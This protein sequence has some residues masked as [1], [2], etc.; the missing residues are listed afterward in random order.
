MNLPQQNI[1]PTLNPPQDVSSELNHVMAEMYKKNLELNERNETLAILRKID[2]IVLS[3]VTDPKLISQMVSDLLTEEEFKLLGL[4][5]IKDTLLLPLA[6]SSKNKSETIN[7]FGKDRFLTPPIPLLDKTNILIKAIDSKQ[8]ISLQNLSEVFK[9]NFSSEE[10]VNIQNEI[11]IQTLIVYPIIVRQESIGALIIGIIEKENELSVYRRSLIDR[12]VGVSGIALDNAIL[13][14]SIQEAN[15][16]LKQLDRL[17]DE[18]VSLASHELRTPMTIIKS[19]L[20]ML[21]NRK[22]KIPPEKEKAYLYRAYESTQRLINLVNDMLNVSRIESGR[23]KL[24]M[25]EL[26]LVSLIEKVVAELVPRAIQLNLTLS[27]FKPQ[28][29]ANPIYAD[30]DRVEQVLIN[31]I[32]NSFKF[33]PSGG[34]INIS[35]TPRDKDILVQV[36]DNGKGMDKI[37]MSAL[38]QKFATMGGNYLTKENIQGTGLGLYLSKSLVEL[39]GGKIWAESPGQGKGSTFSFNL[40]YVPPAKSG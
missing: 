2:E 31:L 13:Y 11:G 23:L 29:K 30:S 10:L 22:A 39:H 38:F 5:I 15:E 25:K 28:V 26:D 14:Q 20:W 21:M 33:T 7:K 34:K 12:L 19:Y 24:E 6:I 16:R 37:Q 1:N 32:G 36:A 17:K 9:K 4:F 40:P 18:F 27:L 3:K 8:T 35:I